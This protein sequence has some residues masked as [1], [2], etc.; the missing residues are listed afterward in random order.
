MADHNDA[1]GAA[2]SVTAQ[3]LD[4]SVPGF[5]SPFSREASSNAKTHSEERIWCHAQPPQ[6]RWP[7]T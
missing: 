3:Q 7:Q 2:H 1:H 5:P 6:T 4:L